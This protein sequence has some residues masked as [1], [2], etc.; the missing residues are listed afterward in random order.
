MPFSLIRV[1]CAT[2][3]MLL[4]SLFLLHSTFLSFMSFIIWYFNQRVFTLGTKCFVLIWRFFASFRMNT[5]H[6][7]T[8][9]FTVSDINT[10]YNS[11]RNKPSAKRIMTL[12][13]FKRHYFVFVLCAALSKLNFTPYPETSMARKSTFYVIRT[14]SALLTNTYLVQQQ[15][16]FPCQM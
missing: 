15:H 14:L 10:R 4:M 6:V 1:L 7:K 3:Q 12:H 5:Q 8:H 9:R 11:F 2:A 16:S 13:H